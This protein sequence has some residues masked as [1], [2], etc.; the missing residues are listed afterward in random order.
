EQDNLQR[1]NTYAELIFTDNVNVG[2]WQYNNTWDTGVKAYQDQKTSGRVKTLIS[3]LDYSGTADPTAPPRHPPHHPD[4]GTW[5][6]VNRVTDGLSNTMFWAEGLAQCQDSNGDVRGGWNF[7]G[8]TWSYN[9]GNSTWQF[10]PQFDAGALA[11]WTWSGSTPTVTY[12]SFE[13]K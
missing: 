1:T 3:P 7:D 10:Q 12:K 13:V 4:G 5:M 6:T 2:S 9:G 11:T 8:T